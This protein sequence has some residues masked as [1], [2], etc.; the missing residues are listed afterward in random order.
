M[1]K[2]NIFAFGAS[3]YMGA[4]QLNKNVFFRF[5]KASGSVPFKPI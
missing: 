4:G 5:N 3:L 2:N 1:Q